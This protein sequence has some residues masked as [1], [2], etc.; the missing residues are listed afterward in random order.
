MKLVFRDLAPAAIAAFA[1]AGLALS[2]VCAGEAAAAPAKNAF[3]V[4]NLV[5][6]AKDPNLR[7]ASGSPSR[8]EVAQSGSPTMLRAARRSMTVPALYNPSSSAFPGP[9]AKV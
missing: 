9:A 1:L 7:N 5:T 8:R 2:G 3:V 6:T 4:T